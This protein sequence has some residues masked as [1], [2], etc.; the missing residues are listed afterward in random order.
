VLSYFASTVYAEEDVRLDLGEEC[1]KAIFRVFRSI[2]P[3][4]PV[5]ADTARHFSWISKIISF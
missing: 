1:Q 5:F 3:Q 2:E 4:I